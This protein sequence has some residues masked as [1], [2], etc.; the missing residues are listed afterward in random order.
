MVLHRLM[1]TAGKCWNVVILLVRSATLNIRHLLCDSTTCLNVVKSSQQIGTELLVLD[2]IIFMYQHPPWRPD[3]A[4][5][6]PTGYRIA[7]SGTAD[8]LQ[9]RISGPSLIHITWQLYIWAAYQSGNGGPTRPTYGQNRDV[10]LGS[11]S[12]S[13]GASRTNFFGLDLGLGLGTCGLGLGLG[14]EK[15]SLLTSLILIRKMIAVMKRPQ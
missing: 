11:W 1:Q 13:R 5:R 12:W 10:V 2:L 8:I 6:Y 3:S 15:K 9:F 4:I 14:L 7:L